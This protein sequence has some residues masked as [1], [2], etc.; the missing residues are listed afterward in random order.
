MAPLP[1]V[2]PS[3]TASTCRRRVVFWCRMLSRQARKKRSPLCT[4][5]ITDT[6][7]AS[8]CGGSGQGSPASHTGFGQMP[9]ARA[10][11]VSS[12]WSEKR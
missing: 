1:S 8:S 3:S 10:A 2:E 7:T 5:T 11:K 9:G 4:G 12:C 6:S